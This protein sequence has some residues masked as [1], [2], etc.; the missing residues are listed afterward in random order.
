VSFLSMDP[1][2][3]KYEAKELRDCVLIGIAASDHEAA[4]ALVDSI[5]DG[6]LGG[7]FRDPSGRLLTRSDPAERPVPILRFQMAASMRVI[8]CGVSGTCVRMLK[9]WRMCYCDRRAKIW[10]WLGGTLRPFSKSR[11]STGR[12]WWIV[13]RCFES[14]RQGTLCVLWPPILLHNPAGGVTSFQMDGLRTRG[15]DG[16]W[17]QAH[18]SRVKKHGS[19]MDFRVLGF[20][21]EFFNIVSKSFRAHILG[22]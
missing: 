7:F 2:T 21:E 12:A 14:V 16:L 8:A 3:A 11:R 4:I 13:S 18:Q 19:K 1:T 20:S 22:S 15:S 17:F 6:S 5:S 9:P 10:G